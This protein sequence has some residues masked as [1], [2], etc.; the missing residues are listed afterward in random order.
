MLASFLMG[1][2]GGQ[3]GITPLAAVS[4]AAARGELPRDNG[5]P[6]ILFHPL[7]AAATVALAAA[8]LAGDKMKSAPDRIVPIGLAT[9]FVSTA[10]AGASLAPRSQRWL[11]G[12]L[13]GTTAVLAAFPG[14]RARVAAMPR[15]GQTP[16]GLV[17]DAIVVLGA[18][19]IL[20]GF[21]RTAAG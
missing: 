6:R 21:G 18:V 1:L 20:R 4:V 17:E 12:M 15:H 9:R 2:V 8:E 3:R 19:A 13:G 14:W 7:V 10:I 16:T 11:G 5:A